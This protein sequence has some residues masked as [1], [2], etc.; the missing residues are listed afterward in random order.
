[1]KLLR[2]TAGHWILA[3]TLL[4]GLLLTGCFSHQPLFL[5]PS[6][7][8][9]VTPMS[10]LQFRVG[11]LV[12]VTLSGNPQ[13]ERDPHVEHIREDGNITLSL[14]GDIQ[15]V[16]KSA[17]QL[18]KEIHD[19]YV[20]G[21]YSYVTVTVR[22]EARMFWVDGEVK[23]PGPKEYVEGMTIVRAISTA[24][25]FT[26][27]AKRWKVRLTRSDGHSEI[28]NVDKAIMDPQKDVPVYP[29]DKINVPRR[30]F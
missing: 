26:D 8:G 1:M 4:A 2:R 28:I 22:G 9:G 21:A 15:A 11:D 18:Q 10:G 19:R 20:P 14:I 13:V 29:G 27:Y 25:G 24:G 3:I 30:L 7:I 17:G 16:G 5:D 6:E 12:I 23:G